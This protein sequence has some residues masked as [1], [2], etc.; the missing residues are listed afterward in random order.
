MLF[1]MTGLFSNTGEVVYLYIL[2][3]YELEIRMSALA[4]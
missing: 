4:F 1:W 2:L 3:L